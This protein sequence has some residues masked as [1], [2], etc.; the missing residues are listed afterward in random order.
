VPHAGR[1]RHNRLLWTVVGLVLLLGGAALALASRGKLGADPSTPLV[2]PT[3]R[4]RWHDGGSWTVAAAI[5]V[6][7]LVAVLGFLLLRAQLRRRAGRPLPPVLAAP[8]SEYI[9]GTTRVST[10]ALHHALTRDLRNH[11]AVRGAGVQLAGRLHRPLV[12]LRL[13]VT[14][15]ADIGAVRGHVDEAMARFA[16]TSGWRPEVAEVTVKLDS[17]PP[18][19]VH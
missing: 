19:R 11:P 7:V 3:A 13:A 15:E 4:Q 2:S 17:R 18:A 16:A 14:P 12:Y 6:A 5:A 8:A 9:P 10:T 1:N